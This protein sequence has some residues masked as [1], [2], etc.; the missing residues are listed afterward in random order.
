MKFSTVP[1][2]A[3]AAA[4][5]L[6]AAS[7]LAADPA[8]TA[9]VVKGKAGAASAPARKGVAVSA[10]PVDINSASKAELMN[11]PGIGAAEAQRIIAGRPYLSKAHLVTRGALSAEAYHGLKT[12]IYARQ[13]GTSKPGG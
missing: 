11:L 8:A 9:A 4:L 13:K 3:L 2:A 6:Y 1:I 12:Q 5:L 10:K 7:S